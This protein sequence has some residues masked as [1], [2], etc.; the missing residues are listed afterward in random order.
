MSKNEINSSIKAMYKIIIIKWV[1]AWILNVETNWLNLYSWQSTWWS[2]SPSFNIP[3][4][5]IND[6][7]VGKI[8]FL[9]FS[10]LQYINHQICFVFLWSETYGVM[11]FKFLIFVYK[12]FFLCLFLMVYFCEFCFCF[13][14]I[15]GSY[16]THTHNHAKTLWLFLIIVESFADH[17]H[18]HWLVFRWPGFIPARSGLF[19]VWLPF[20]QISAYSFHWL[21]FIGILPTCGFSSPCGGIFHFIDMAPEFVIISLSGITELSCHTHI[22]SPHTHKHRTQKFY[23]KNSFISNEKN[24]MTYK[25]ELNAIRTTEWPEY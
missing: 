9:F 5:Q 2:T 13:S 25:S 21:F 24:R 15:T 8:F 14:S 11:L 1:V 19:I 3:L 18:Y 23:V 16:F 10:F 22:I 7:N 17:H 20:C 12:F 6:R 4:R